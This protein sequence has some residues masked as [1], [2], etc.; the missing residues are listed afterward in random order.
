MIHFEGS[1]NVK[2]TQ[3]ARFQRFKKFVRFAHL[4]PSDFYF[5]KTAFSEA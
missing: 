2:K 1:E 3:G 5:R 4:R